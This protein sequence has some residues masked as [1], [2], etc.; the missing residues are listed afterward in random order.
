VEQL[1]V[2]PFSRQ[3]RCAGKK[4]ARLTSSTG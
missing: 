4:S 3:R 2:S 1:Y